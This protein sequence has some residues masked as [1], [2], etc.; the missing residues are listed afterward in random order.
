MQRRF[1]GLR[2][3]AACLEAGSEVLGFDTPVSVDHGWGPHVTLFVTAPEWTP[4]L[5]TEVRRVM[6]DELPFEFRGYSTHFAQPWSAMTP[7]RSVPSTTASGWP[8]PPA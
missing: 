3:G 6:A 5:A 2:H 8:T 1:T 4:E 7:P